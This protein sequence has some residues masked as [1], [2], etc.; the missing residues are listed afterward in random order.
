MSLI[1]MFRTFLLL[2]LHFQSFM[3]HLNPIFQSF[4]PT[5]LYPSQ[6]VNSASPR[7]SVPYAPLLPTSCFEDSATITHFGYIF[8]VIFSPDIILKIVY[9]DPVMTTTSFTTVN[10]NSLKFVFIF[11]HVGELLVS[12][13]FEELDFFVVSLNLWFN[14]TWR[15]SSSVTQV[16]INFD[17]IHL[18]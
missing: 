8:I 16:C 13:L 18:L 7:P 5:N 14:S 10:K 2:H 9:V 6:E 3:M 1:H 12:L 4:R 11:C 17:I 15:S